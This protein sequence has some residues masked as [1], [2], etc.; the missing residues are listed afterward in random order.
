MGQYT[1]YFLYEKY[2][3]RGEQEAIP[4]YPNVYSID[5]DGTMQKVIKLEDDPQCGYDPPIGPIYKWVNIP[6]TQD[7]ICEDC[8]I[9]AIYRWVNM[10]A[11]VDY[12]CEGTTKYYKQKKQVSYDSGAT[13]TDVV[14]P[15]YQ[16]G[17]VAETESTDCG[18]IPPQPEP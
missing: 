14:P 9:T 12:Y 3:K 8:E 7:Y 1:S 16:K 17:E 6:I 15:E 11:S 10:D 4:V 18:Y 13:W 2:E 5:A